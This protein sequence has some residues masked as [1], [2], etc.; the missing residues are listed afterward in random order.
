M[1]FE[2]LLPNLVF[3]VALYCMAAAAFGRLMRQFEGI[4]RYHT[5][6]AIGLVLGLTAIAGMLA[7]VTV[8]D[9]VV[10][11]GRSIAVTA[12]GLFGGPVGA[13]AAVLPP[14]LYRIELGGAGVLPGLI[15]LALAGALGAGLR[16]TA[17]RKS[18][19]LGFRHVVIAAAL[20]PFATFMSLPFMPTV[21]LAWTVFQEVGMAVAAGMP[22]GL[23]LLGELL[24]TEDQRHGLLTELRADEAI[25]K[26]LKA[27]MPAM[28]FQR[29]LTPEGDSKFLFV[30][31]SS[32]RLLDRTPEELYANSSAMFDAV[33]PDDRAQF[34]ATIRA[35]EQEGVLL[36]HEYRS[37]SREG[38]VRWLR[39]SASATLV[40]GAYLWSGFVIDVTKLKVAERKQSE[41]AQMVSDSAVPIIRT[42]A[43]F[44]VNYFNGAAE[45]LYGYA[46]EEVIGGPAAMFRPPERVE[47]MAP[48]LDELKT[49]RRASSIRTLSLHKSGRRIP[50]RLD[51][52]PLFD[53]LGELTGWA[54]MC[55]DM[56]EQ[57]A[58][59]EELQR[60]ATTDAL[61]GLANRRSFGERAAQEIGRARRYKRPLALIMADIDHF[62]QI[63]DTFGHGAG[64]TV[65]VK[66]AGV[67]EHTLRSSGDLAARLGGEEFAVLLPECDR[68]GAAL[69]AERL[70]IAIAA[71]RISCNG[72]E[73][74]VRCSF[75]VSEWHPAEDAVEAALQ[76]ADAALYAAKNSGRDRVVVSERPKDA[77]PLKNADVAPVS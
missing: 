66:A 44:N 56:T 8:A 19:A 74:Q 32:R 21:D 6:A 33:H 51:L 7:P 55:L 69:L 68:K 3:H 17:L 34:M 22:I 38:V 72:Q 52:S 59:E 24:L 50:T 58:A 5:D 57:Q 31:E 18:G 28:L 64:D 61:T 71:M 30:S 4:A 29:T 53:E 45:R 76:R 11:D 77:V 26:T 25:F 70:R 42:D 15:N 63:N 12:A 60:L 75:G 14:A 23:L 36:S 35:A 47:A 49:T 65:L 48:L 67:L 39:V 37:L 13:L 9:G 10:L 43:N 20:L 62:K 73:I 46:A 40:D 16:W 1:L 54:A 2:E 41:L 27:D